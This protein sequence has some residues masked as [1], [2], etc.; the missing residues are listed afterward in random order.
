MNNNVSGF[1]AADGSFTI[2]KSALAPENP[3]RPETQ[4]IIMEM[5]EICLD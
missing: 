4:R 1:P 3:G 2:R 5:M